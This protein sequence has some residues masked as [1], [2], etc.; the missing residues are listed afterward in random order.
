MISLAAVGRIARIACGATMRWSWRCLG[1]P[2]A[3]AAS[4]CPGST[5]MMPERTISAA[6]AAWW[7]LSPSSAA[8]NSLT[9]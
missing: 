4:N 6:Y 8:P 1:M 7:R 9:K 3:A 2:S 5:E